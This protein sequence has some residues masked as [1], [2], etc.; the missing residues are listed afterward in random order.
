MKRSRL[1]WLMRTTALAVTVTLVGACGDDSDDGGPDGGGLDAASE[2]A[3]L[4]DSIVGQFVDDNEALSTLD[5]LGPIIAG[6]TSSSPTELSRVAELYRQPSG[7]RVTSRIEPVGRLA[8]QVI[9]LL[10]R[11]PDNLLG[12]TCI[13]DVN[14]LPE[15]V[16]IDGGRTG[17]PGNGIR[18]VLYQLNSSGTGLQMPLVENGRI[19]ITDNSTTGSIDVSLEAV[20]DGETLLSVSAIGTFT[21]ADFNLTIAGFL[22]GGGETLDFSFSI[23]GDPNTGANAGSFSLDL[24]PLSVGFTFD[25]DETGAGTNFVFIT[26]NTTQDQLEL[27]FDFDSA[28]NLL[29]GSVVLFN[30]E[31]V[32]TITGTLASGTLTA[33]DGSPLTTSDLI[34]LANVFN[35]LSEIFVVMFELF[36]LGLLL[37]GVGV[38]VT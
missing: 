18:F 17:A 15:L 32:A 33:T 37:I 34:A 35:G 7:V 10:A 3:I 20:V 28:G 8:P 1:L 2:S 5:V 16:Y 36:V 13:L 4:V 24:G 19:D 11:I 22:G 38:T 27:I 9:S 6:V 23:N 21:T 25:V 14:A 12:V 26:D 31:V 30:G 29:S